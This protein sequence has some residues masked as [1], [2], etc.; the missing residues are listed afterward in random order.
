MGF[1]GSFDKLRH[2]LPL[3]RLEILLSRTVWSVMVQLLITH[4][5]WRFP[6]STSPL[7]L[8]QNS[9]MDL[10]GLLWLKILALLNSA[11]I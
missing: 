1:V 10:F 3:S 4:S 5:I 9:L 8:H 6:S 2:Y 7:L 11:W